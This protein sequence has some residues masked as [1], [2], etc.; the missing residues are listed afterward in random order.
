MASGGDSIEITCNHPTLGQFVFKPKSAEDV[1]VNLG[2][3]RSNDDNNM[4]TGSGEMIDQMN[5]S[6][7]S[8][9][10]T[11]AWDMQLGLDLEKAS[12][13]ASSPVLGDWTISNINGTTYGGKGKPVGDLEG[14]SNAVTF[15]LKVAGGGRMAKIAG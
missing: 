11:C 12:A 10:A 1:T 15:T 2:G 4:L 14:N 7:W 5:N 9:E 3:F 13:L 8:F 6:R